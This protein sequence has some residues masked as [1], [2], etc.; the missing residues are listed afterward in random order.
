M[1]KTPLENSIAE[2]ITGRSGAKLTEGTLRRYQ[3]EMLRRTIEYALE[4][5]PFYCREFNGFTPEDLRR[6]EDL[7]V[8]PFTRPEDFRDRGPEFLCVSQSE[9][10]RVTTLVTPG[11]LAQPRRTYFTLEDLELT[12]DFFHYGM[13]TFV[14]PWQRVL[15]LMPGERPGSVGDLLARGLKRMDV[16]AIVYGGVKDPS[17]AVSE[18]VER[19]VHCLVGIPDQVLSIARHDTTQRIPRGQMKSVLLSAD[20]CMRTGHIPGAIVEELQRTWG[21][22]VFNHYATTEMG[23][24]AAL[25][26]EALGGYHLR[27]ADLYFEIVDPETGQLQPAG[28][29]GEIVFTT[30]TRTGMPLVRY[31]TGDLARFLTE[32]CPCGTM[33]RRM[34]KVRGRLHDMVKLRTGEWLGIADLDEAI[35]PISGVLGY[36]VTL[37]TEFGIDRLDILV[38]NRVKAPVDEAMVT[39][40][41]LRVPAIRQAV[42]Q[43]SLIVGPI[44]LGSVNEATTGLTKRTIVRRHAGN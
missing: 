34:E 27:E 6:V 29:L 35:L 23:F 22:P 11:A 26:C 37:F 43:G 36:S 41:L 2:K 32:P 4:K 17:H 9:I 16:E 24:G 21:C 7:A 42:Q 14:E 3:V 44:K 15:I 18:I 38:N 10:E 28:E 40:A 19:K 39:D 33:L 1:R 8:L 25:E 12:I 30:L 13:S 5:S 20:A 31:R